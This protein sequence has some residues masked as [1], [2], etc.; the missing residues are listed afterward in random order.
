MRSAEAPGSVGNLIAGFDLLGLCLEGPV[1]RIRAEVTDIPGVVIRRIT[2]DGGRL[3]TSPEDN[4]AAV[5][6]TA[7]L[8]GRPDPPGVALTVE[9]GLPLSGGMGGS[10]ASAVAAVVAVN[11]LLGMGADMDTLYRAA[12]AGEARISGGEHGDNVAPSL[13]GGITLSRI[14]RPVVSLPVPHGLSVALLHPRLELSTRE[15]RGALPATV[16]MAD[17]VAQAGHTAALVHALHSGDATL[18]ASALEDRLA[19]PWRR[20]RIPGFAHLREAALGAGA[21]GFGISGAGP[22]VLA[23]AE[24]RAVAERVGEA[25]KAAFLGAAGMEAH[26]HLSGVGRGAQVI[27]EEGELP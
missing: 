2:G 15:L 11:A 24:N 19:E 26:L 8:R 17:A 6:V 14:G 3:P 22:A 5:A 27:E 25:M 10:A 20:D 18:L 9:K 1:D 7:L 12:L 21:L 16:P 13:F 23:L 4:S